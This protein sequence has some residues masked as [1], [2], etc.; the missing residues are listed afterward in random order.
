VP[1]ATT[2]RYAGARL[3][4]IRYPYWARGDHT[5]VR[6]GRTRRAVG[7][8]RAAVKVV[9]AIASLPWVAYRLLAG[10]CWRP[11]ANAATGGQLDHIGWRRAV[12]PWAPRCRARG[13]DADVHHGYDVTGLAAAVEAAGTSVA[14]VVHDSHE[15]YA[16]S[17][18]MRQ[19]PIARWW[20]RSLERRLSAAPSHS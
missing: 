6:S 11:A 19:G 3:A 15:L 18:R 17:G 13:S 5:P 20:I 7:L 9:L 12:L 10:A 2:V 4:W 8:D 14:Q 16:E 1:L